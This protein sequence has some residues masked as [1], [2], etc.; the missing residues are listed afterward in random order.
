MRFVQLLVSLLCLS[1]RR[2]FDS[3]R[4]IAA[5][6]LKV[7]AGAAFVASVVSDG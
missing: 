3:M 7:I 1:Q 6:P 2:S 5:K 4:G